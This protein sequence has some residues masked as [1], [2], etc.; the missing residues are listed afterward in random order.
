MSFMFK[1]VEIVDTSCLRVQYAD[2]KPHLHYYEVRHADEDFGYAC[3][4]A[5]GIM[6][7]HL[8]TLVAADQIEE[9]EQGYV[10]LTEE[11]SELI[12]NYL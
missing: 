9:A 7:N 4:L 12:G 2:R 11:E 3:Q 5:K 1:G 10:D 8:G 6:V